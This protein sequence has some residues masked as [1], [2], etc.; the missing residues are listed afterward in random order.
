MGAYINSPDISKE[1]WLKNHA[2]EV[3]FDKMTWKETPK[4]NLPVIL[5]HNGFFT[6]AVIAYSEVEFDVFMDVEDKRPK[7]FFYAEECKL[8]TVSPDLHR[9]LVLNN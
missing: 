8:H 2:V 6:A 4:G 3:S 7:R 1:E 5:V 9:Y